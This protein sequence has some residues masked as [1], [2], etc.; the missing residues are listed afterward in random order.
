M[1]QACRL[2]KRSGNLPPV[3]CKA[4]ALSGVRTYLMGTLGRD[5][6]FLSGVR[7]YLQGIVGQGCRLFKRCQKLHPRH[8]WAGLQPV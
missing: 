3:H 5:A 8:Y 2:L 1:R 6:A 4:G 7:T